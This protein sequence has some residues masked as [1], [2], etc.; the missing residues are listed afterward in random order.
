MTVPDYVPPGGAPT[1]AVHNAPAPSAQW[2]GLSQDQLSALRTQ[3]VTSII[4]VVVK[5]VTGIF[6]PG[7]GIGGATSQ[8]TDWAS[9]IPV[10]GDLL[11]GDFITQLIDTLGGNSSFLS[12]ITDPVNQLAQTIFQALTGFTSLGTL[13]EDVADALN[14]IPFL[15]ILGVGGPANIGSSVT[16][17]WDHL[18]S[19]Y[20]GAIG[21]GANLA[22]LFNIGQAV[23]S[24]ATLGKFS[25]DILGVRNDN[26][27]NTG[28]L[29]TTQSNISLDKIALGST[30]MSTF[31]ITQSTAITAYHL[32]SR[33]SDFGV[34][35]WQGSGVTS[36]T[37][38]FVNIFKM[39]TTTGQ[40]TLVHGSA[41]IVGSL[42][43][44]MQQN[45]YSLPT[46]IS[47]LPGDVFGIE[48]AIRGAGTHLIGGAA[49]GLPDQTVFPRRY[50][51]VRNSGTSAPPSTLTPSYGTNVPFVEFGVTASNVPLPHSPDIQMFSVAGSSSYPIPDWANFVDRVM[52][53]GGGGG[54]QGGTWGIGGAGG[55]V[56]AWAWDTLERDVHFS[57]GMSLTTAVGAG[58]SAGVGGNGGNGG[59]S[60][61]SLITGHVLN[62]VGGL[63]ATSFDVIGSAHSGK[64]PG[65]F[66]FPGGGPAWLIAGGVAQGTYGA[67]GNG[68]GGAGAG[69]NW[70]SLQPG[71]PGA[72]GII[73]YRFRQS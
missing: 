53:P 8:L 54:H 58:G 13:L 68:P 45:V 38:A 70:I 18:L 12:M 24:G 47:V 48:I 15:S 31:G 59:G 42:S 4:Q 51:S 65:N 3:L 62:T 20:V 49:S 72:D 39:D 52:L 26:Q 5:A 41:N 27:L 32:I 17:G 56:G 73:L 21:S 57:A 16:S 30:T 29:P 9:N 55:D 69:G 14:H 33:A 60:T 1:Q 71:G 28:F 50:S 19:G 11:S 64:S 2:Q 36:I 10:I 66:A 44:S 22:D 40:N 43:G 63:G 35:S 67:K 6:V 23:S 46:P 25:F 7:G 37:D 34:V 61:S